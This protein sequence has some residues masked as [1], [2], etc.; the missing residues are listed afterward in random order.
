[1]RYFWPIG[2]FNMDDVLWVRPMFLWS[3]W[4]DFMASFTVGMCKMT[5]S[6]TGGGRLCRAR[7]GVLVVKFSFGV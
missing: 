7:G 4:L 2:S 1:M 6:P 3:A 5:F